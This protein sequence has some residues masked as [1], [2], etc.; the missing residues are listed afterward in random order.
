MIS[1]QHESDTKYAMTNPQEFPPRSRWNAFPDV[2]IHAPESRVVQHHRYAAAKS[3]DADAA[4]DLVK[5]TISD[6]AVKALRALAADRS[7]ILVS[8]HAFEKYGVNAIPETLADELGRHTDWG[9]DS[10]VVQKNVV[11][12]TGADGFSRLAKQAAF[13]GL[14][15]PG[16][17]YLLVDDF[18]GQ[19]GTLAN[20]KGH[21]EAH[22]GTVVGATVLTG[23]PFSAKLALSN[24]QLH[25]LR[26]KHGTELEKW[27][28]NQF[29]HGFDCLTQSE[30]RY[31]ERSPDA[32][33]IRNKIIEAKQAGNRGEK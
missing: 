18:I 14:I 32:D 30:A 17:D 9:T 25:A 29:G 10:A 15:V 27:W 2:I 5:E 21:I 13:D 11:E 33:A 22:G 24:D 23:K 19:G 6:D 26:K 16:K 4:L 12:H 1:C 28:Q 8:A 31:L 20:L 7:P 3:G